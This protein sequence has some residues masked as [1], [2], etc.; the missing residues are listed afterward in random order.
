MTIGTS[1]RHGPFDGRWPSGRRD[2]L[3][4][5]PAP[6]LLAADIPERL[7]WAAFSAR[8]FRGRRRHNLEALSAY[9][10]YTTD[11]EWRTSGGPRTPRL[12]LVSSNEPGPPAIEAESDGAG[13]RRLLAAV[14]AV[15][16]W[17]GE[18]G[19]TP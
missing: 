12:R 19:Y 8:Y 5:V 13:T 1:R 16:V 2:G 9:A 17:E 3:D 14:A 7:D 6:A 15:Q 10:A 18:G 4:G 11:R